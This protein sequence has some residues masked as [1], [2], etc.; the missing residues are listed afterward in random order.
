MKEVSKK[1]TPPAE[2]PTLDPYSAH[3]P[4]PVPDV[5]ESDS[6]TVWGMWE[7]EEAKEKEQEKEQVDRGFAPTVPSELQPLP[8]D[9]PPK[10]KT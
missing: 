1:P 5:V 7:A 8:S 4:I 6:D 3:D 9:T 2:P 10:R